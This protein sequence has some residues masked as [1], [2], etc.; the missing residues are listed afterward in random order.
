M[1][2]NLKRVISNESLFVVDG[3]RTDDRHGRDVLVAIAK[4]TYA[5]ASS[6]VVTIA[7]PPSP[8][9]AVP[10][11]SRPDRVSSLRFPSDHVDE[12]PGTDVLFLGTAHPP[13]GQ[14]VTEMD[15]AIRVDTKTRSIQ[16]RVRVSGSRIWYSAL[17]KV[18]P[19]PPDSLGPTALIYESA[20]GGCDETDALNPHVD[21]RNPVGMGVVRD[22]SKRIGKLAPPI[23]D[24]R[25]PLSSSNPAPGGFAPIAPDWEP[26]SQW[27]GTCDEAWSRTRA[28]IRPVD[29][30]PRHNCCAPSDLWSEIPL[31]GNE[32]VEVLGMTPA[33]TWRF[34]LPLYA[35]TFEAA[36]FGKIIEYQTHLDTFLVDAD[37]GRVEL[38]WRTSIPLPRKS[39]WLETVRIRGRGDDAFRDVV[40]RTLCE[41]I[42]GKAPQQN[43]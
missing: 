13:A 23:E 3:L 37:S 41:R 40:G 17:N 20:Y 43:H 15:V 24:Y 16:K 26:R 34:R 27:A 14:S 32:A 19:G 30:D 28:P 29:F 12:K 10:V 1:L 4:I 22:P 7:D 2:M 42:I 8:I 9:R 11:S 5:V 6:G 39:Q 18:V 38:V 35:P 31:L 25:A 21:W 36:I 33:G